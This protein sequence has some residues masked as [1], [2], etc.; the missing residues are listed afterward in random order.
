[1]TGGI[2]DGWATLARELQQELSRLDSPPERIVASI[3][4]IGLLRFTVH[5]DRGSRKRAKALVGKY[6]SLAF[7][8]CERCG[9]P[10]SVRAGVIVTVRCAGCGEP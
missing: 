4:T 9:E 6:E 3:D 10:G 8:R 7:G 2:G 5:G 1:V